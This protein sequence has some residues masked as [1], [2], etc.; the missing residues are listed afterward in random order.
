M[1][2]E[3]GGGGCGGRERGEGLCGERKRNSTCSNHVL[4]K[5]ERKF[6]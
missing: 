1:G 2:L 6:L 4:N 5:L 3:G